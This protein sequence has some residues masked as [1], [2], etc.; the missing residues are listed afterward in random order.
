[1][2]K[3][4]TTTGAPRPAV[5]VIFCYPALLSASKA[6]APIKS[7]CQ[8]HWGSGESLSQ[9][10]NPITA[11]FMATKK[12]LSIREGFFAFNSLTAVRGIATFY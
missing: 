9:T 1:L 11:Y 8:A 3:T 7:P 12:A 5:A 6:T 10:F 2:N 4:K